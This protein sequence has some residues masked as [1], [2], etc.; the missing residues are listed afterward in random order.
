MPHVCEV[1]GGSCTPMPPPR[2]ARAAE[3]QNG[4]AARA[5][6]GGQGEGHPGSEST[7]GAQLAGTTGLAFE[8][9]RLAQLAGAINERLADRPWVNSLRRWHAGEPL[10]LFRRKTLAVMIARARDSSLDWE[11]CA[12]AKALP[13]RNH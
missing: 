9:E 12:R 1:H 6:V 3:R 8:G 2:P 7:R 5:A 11:E 13:E 4:L 10:S